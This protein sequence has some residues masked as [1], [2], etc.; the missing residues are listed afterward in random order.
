MKL[1]R[2]DSDTVTIE[3]KLTRDELDI[4]GVEFAAMKVNLGNGH[5]QN[6]YPLTVGLLKDLTL[7]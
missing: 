7:L 2:I 3:L 6:A 1:E 5:L 4:L